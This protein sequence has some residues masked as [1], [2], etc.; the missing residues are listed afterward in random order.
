[1]NRIIERL[2]A[3]FSPEQI[4]DYLF[5]RLLPD[6]IVAAITFF[7]FLVLWN[8]LSRTLG[9]VLKRA[10]LDLT[11]QNFVKMVVKYTVLTIGVVTALSQLGINT[12]SVVASLGVAGLTIGFAARDTLSNVISGIFIFWDRPFVVDDFV[13]IDGHYGRVAEIT[14]RST[15]VVTVDGKMLAIPNSQV[16]NSTVSSYTNFAHLRIDVDVTVGVNEDLGRVRRILLDLIEDDERFL[17]EPAASVVVTALN[18]YNVAVQL[19]VWLDDERQHVPV[20]FE[21]RERVF[22]ALRSAGVE[23]P[24][25]TIQLT[26]IE[27]RESARAETPA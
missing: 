15:R 27:V 18:D 14:M 9:V 20:R 22:E 10:K 13:E 7:A 6:L 21:L 12:G 4:F 17:D 25:E 24:Y 16:V 11:A 2:G 1:M 3:I 19:R 23:L 5:G 26:P 8:F